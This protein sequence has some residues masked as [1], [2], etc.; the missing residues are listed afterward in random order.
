MSQTINTAGYKIVTTLDANLQNYGQN[1]IWTQSGLDASHSGGYIL[2]MPS[3]T[4]ST[5]AVTSM[6]TDVKYGV[7]KGDPGYSVD[8][9]FTKGYAGSGSTYKYFTALTALKMGVPTNYTLT[10]NNNEWTTKNCPVDDQTGKPYTVHNAGNY[11][12]TMPLDHALPASSNTYFVAMEDQTFSCELGP[13]V[14]TA[15]GL[16]MNQLKNHVYDGQGNDTGRTIA[17]SVVSGRQATFTLGPGSDLG[18]GADR[19]LLGG[20]QR[21]CVLPAD[22]DPDG[23]PTSTASRCRSSGPAAAASSTRTPRG[24]W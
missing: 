13:I 16:G 20:G 3:V 11:S 10:T 19:C 8:H 2:A 7:K 18:A 24:R 14:N 1:N 17:Q 12:S 21:R 23:R 22:P 5:G 6:I 9:L 4:P 15:L